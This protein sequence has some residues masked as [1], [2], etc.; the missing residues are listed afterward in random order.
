MGEKSLKIINTKNHII[1]V[2]VISIC[3]GFIIPVSFKNI[4]TE[5]HKISDD[6]YSSGPISPILIDD[7]PGSSNDWIWAS[8]QPWFYG[9]SG[10]E[11]DPYMLKDLI[12]DG[13]GVSNCI[14]IENSI[15]YFK[16]Q[17][18]TLYNAG[19]GMN[20]DAGIYL[21]NVSNGILYL[22][23]CSN[24][25]YYGISLYESSHNH[26]EGNFMNGY[27]SGA[28]INL[29]LS[30]NNT[31]GNNQ[32][33]YKYQ[34]IRLE[35]S[36]NNLIMDNTV[37]ENTNYGILVMTNSHHNTISGNT[38]ANQT[39][40]SG[41]LILNSDNN[42][43]SD[44]T[45][46]FNPKAGI[47]ID[48][49]SSN[50]IAN[51]MVFNNTESGISVW[52]NLGSGNGYD[53]YLTGNVIHGNGNGIYLS[54]TSDNQIL[55]NEVV[56]NNQIGIAIALNVNNSIISN[57]YLLT[58]GNHAFDHGLNNDWNGNY[59]DNYSASDDNNDGIGDIPYNIPG[60]SNSKDYVP[61]WD[62]RDPIIDIMAPLHGVSV[63]RVAPEFIV[64]IYDPYL[65]S[66]WYSI[67]TENIP[68]TANG[69]IDQQHWET[70]WDALE[71]GDSITITFY[72][73]DTFGHLGLDF[74]E[75]TKETPSEPTNGI[76]LDYGSALFFIMIF[77]GISIVFVMIK[78]HSKKRIFNS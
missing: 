78:I 71:Q 51:N 56:N 66:M 22:N 33:K 27:D 76:G 48:A 77:S 75:V 32:I 9:G 65:D 69:T 3:L 31:V 36:S 52:T 55:D 19:S 10:V 12:I 59:W 60:G 28:G 14:T 68:F 37:E 23:N 38:A 5:N 72:A 29:H 54:N 40:E 73:N 63:S 64:Y 16:I 6:I 1:S 15:S 25:M 57:N 74:V 30:H 17:N 62:D 45:L 11:G 44:N 67:D 13:G 47:E 43:I 41:I 21:N 8:T 4:C 53:N 20:S 42:Y 34:G 58:N 46:L 24:I 49:S 35:T 70:L 18:C 61:I 26:V 39:Y 50:T 2:I 7:S